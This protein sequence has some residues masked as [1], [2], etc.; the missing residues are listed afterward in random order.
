LVPVAL[1][2]DGPLCR[3]RPS[4]VFTGLARS[5]P[6]NRGV[7]RPPSARA[8]L[9]SLAGLVGSRGRLR[10][11]PQ[12][13]AYAAA[14]Q[15]GRTRPV[16]RPRPPPPPGHVVSDVGGAARRWPGTCRQHGRGD[17]SRLVFLLDPPNARCRA[18]LPSSCRLRY[19]PLCHGS[20]GPAEW[21]S[22]SGRPTST[23]CDAPHAPPNKAVLR[24]PFSPVTRRSG[25]AGRRQRPGQSHHLVAGPS[26]AG[27]TP[28]GPEPR[29]RGW[30][31]PC[32]KRNRS[33]SLAAASES[34]PPGPPPSGPL[35]RR[36][37]WSRNPRRCCDVGV[38]SRRL[39]R[40]AATPG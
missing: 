9:G 24:S 1:I 8:A 36:A 18:A 15:R 13:A 20:R 30:S 34:R 22:Q 21:A 19:A 28:G 35:G 39:Y 7:A 16:Q 37:S 17:G 27:S 6:S 25:R 5:K 29:G 11:P 14:F 3:P 31:T 26:G 38:L 12:R 2:P 23:N 40:V 4:P 32:P 33:P 10:R